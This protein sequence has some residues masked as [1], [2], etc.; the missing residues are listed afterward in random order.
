MS[1]SSLDGTASHNIVVAI[2]GANECELRSSSMRRS[3]TIGRRSRRVRP[4]AAI[5][6]PPAS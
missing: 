3:P 2:T 5:R 6:M 1:V 4:A